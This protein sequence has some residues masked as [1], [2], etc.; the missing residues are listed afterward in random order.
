M[1]ILSIFSVESDK[2]KAY[3]YFKNPCLY[4][5]IELNYN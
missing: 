4:Q 2:L 3:E 1:S 5:L